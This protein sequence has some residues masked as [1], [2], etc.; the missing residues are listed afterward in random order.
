MADDQIETY[1][2]TCMQLVNQ[3][4]QVIE[5]AFYEKKKVESKSCNLD[6]VTE[7]DQEVEKLLINGLRKAFPDHRFIGEE[8]TAGGEKCVL[9]DAPTWIIDPVDGTT[10]FVHSLPLIAISIGLLVEK[11]AVLGIIHNPILKQTYSAKAGAGAFFNGNPIK[12]SG[13]TE[14]AKSLICTESG[15]S[16]DPVKLNVILQNLQS[17]LGKCHGT[18]S[19]G[20]AAITMATVAMGG[21]DAYYEFGLHAWDMAAGELIVR[22]A[23]GTV[24]DTTGGPFDLMSRRVVCAGSEKLAKDIAAKLVQ[25]E[26]ERD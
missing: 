7:T 16:D 20:S 8:S 25:Y 12:V 9:T 19:L 24:V 5:G 4:S 18:R 10:N 6:L 11:K 13:E 26:M 23:G 15:S 17:L 22:E 3:A 21:V 2:S 1:F 14:M